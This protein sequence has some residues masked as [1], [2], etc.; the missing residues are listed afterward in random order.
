MEIDKTFFQLNCRR[1]WRE[2]P[3]KS[4]RSAC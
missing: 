2:A 3:L 4:L 1:S